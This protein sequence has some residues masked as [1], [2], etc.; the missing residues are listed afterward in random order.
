M[1]NPSGTGNHQEQHTHVNPS[2][3]NGNSVPESSSG[4]VV[5]MKHNPGISLDWTPEEQATLEDGLTKYVNFLFSYHIILNYEYAIII[6]YLC[7]LSLMFILRDEFL[8]IT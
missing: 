3:F 2:S 7:V 8:L 6:S 4:L 1:A 5:N